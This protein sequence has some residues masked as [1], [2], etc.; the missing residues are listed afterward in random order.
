MVDV[1]PEERL[2]YQDT[3]ERFDVIS[4]GST[5][6]IPVEFL[7]IKS[8]RTDWVRGD[9]IPATHGPCDQVE[10]FVAGRRLRKNP[11]MI[12]NSELGAASPAGDVFHEA[13]FSVDGINRTIRLTE[14]APV[15]TR[16]TVFRKIGRLW[17]DEGDTTAS[18]GVT[19]LDN[20]TPVAKFISLKTSL[21]PD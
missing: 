10:V 14:P 16:I 5:H 21:L 18:N 6:E 13:E 15:N 7:P 3:E 4:D 1:S 17:Y 20:S 9:S 12:F 2:P 8:A 19:L 11:V